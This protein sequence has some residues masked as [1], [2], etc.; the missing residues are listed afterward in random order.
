MNLTTLE[1]RLR[2]L[3]GD[4]EHEDNSDGW[5][6]DQVID[7]LNWAQ[8]RYTEATHCTYT[9]VQV[10]VDENGYLDLT[11]PDPVSDSGVLDVDRVITPEDESN[12]E[13]TI[14]VGPWYLDST[15]FTA[16][17]DEQIGATYLWS[18]AGGVIAS[19]QGTNSIVVTRSTVGR[20]TLS[21]AVTL[22]R[23]TVR[24]TSYVDVEETA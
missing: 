12:P 19:G 18:V 21:V 4:V 23:K 5:D 6:Q 7:A 22:D 17:V 3:I 1:A 15:P 14:S 8:D 10:D 16:S 2:E 24:G 9:E 11:W 20:V 13:A